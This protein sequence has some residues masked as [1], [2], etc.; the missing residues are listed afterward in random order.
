[1]GATA[2]V[3]LDG[4]SLVTT[5]ATTSPA[6]GTSESWTVTALA[7]TIPALKAG[8][9][10][11]LVDANPLASAAQLADITRVTACTGSGAT[12]IT[13]TRGVDGSTPVAHSNP[14][15]FNVITTASWLNYTRS[16]AQS[17]VAAP[18]RLLNRYSQVS[19]AYNFNSRVMHAARAALQK[20]AHGDADCNIL[21]I[22]D[23]TLVG[24]DDTTYLYSGCIPRQMGLALATILGV[25]FGGGIQQGVVDATHSGDRWTL[26]GTWAAAT[27]FLSSSGTGTATWVSLDAGEVAEFYISNLSTTGMAWTIDGVAQTAVTTTGANT[28]QKVTVSGLSNAT[29]TLVFTGAAAHNF[30]IFGIR[31]YRTSVKQL[32]VHNMAIGGARAN[33]GTNGQNWNSVQ[34]TAP[35]GLGYTAPLTITAAGITP[36][37]VVC[38]LGNNDAFQSVAAA[39]ALTG[40]TNEHG[41][42]PSIPWIFMHPPMVPGTTQSIYDALG[43]GFYDTI[44]DTLDVAYFDWNDWVNTTTS[45]V[46]DGL[47][48]ASNTHP[49][50]AHQKAVGLK[51]AQL[52][53][54]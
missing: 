18:A 10:Y 6:S 28:L 36:D 41:Y 16:S 47:A 12:T 37:F 29:H 5:S 22:G 25:P 33:S 27:N 4:Q 19:N 14:C 54:A 13:V 44:A 7:A 11:A 35:T 15:T 9:T 38:C 32:Y 53:A 31:V 49:T 51:L 48:G 2:D 24:Y 52:I 42:Y 39:T 46:A 30:F 21:C 1:M 50:F 40:L 17:S 45:F 26:T 3:Q 43:A 23:S 34:T 20:L 8:Q